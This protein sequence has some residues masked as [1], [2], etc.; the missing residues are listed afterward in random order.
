MNKTTMDITP[1][2]I[3]YWDGNILSPAEVRPCC[4][5][6]NVVDYAIYTDNLLLFTI[7][8]SNEDD[9][10][11]VISLK[12]ADKNIDDVVIQSIGSEIDRHNRE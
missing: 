10:K 11:W 1:Y 8:K 3:I 9:G 5:E 12:N 4:R 2:K 6:D 7:T